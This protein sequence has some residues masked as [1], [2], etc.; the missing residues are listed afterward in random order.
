M[1]NNISLDTVINDDPTLK[2]LIR[3]A[4]YRPEIFEHQLDIRFGALKVAINKWIH[5]NYH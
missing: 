4:E 3:D 5:V 1:E 2:Y